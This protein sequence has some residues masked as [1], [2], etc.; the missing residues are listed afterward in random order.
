MDR[1]LAPRSLL[2]LHAMPGFDSSLP[3]LPLPGEVGYDAARGQG[4]GGEES[5]KSGEETNQ[6]CW[7]FSS[8]L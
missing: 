7:I 5:A 4:E 6:N 1:S 2:V 8:K 3:G